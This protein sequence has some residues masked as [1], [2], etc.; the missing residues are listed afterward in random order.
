MDSR[1][2]QN[3][4]NRDGYVYIENVFCTERQIWYFTGTGKDLKRKKILRIWN[5]VPNDF[6]FTFIDSQG[7]N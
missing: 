4:H 6:Q 7:E 3:T 1:E 5:N 2:E